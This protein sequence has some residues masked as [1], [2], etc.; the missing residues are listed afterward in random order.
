METCPGEQI[1][2]HGPDN[3][4]I[5]GAGWISDHVFAIETRQTARRGRFY[6]FHLSPDR[7]KNPT[8][9]DPTRALLSR[10]FPEYVLLLHGH[11]IRLPSRLRRPLFRRHHHPICSHLRARDQATGKDYLDGGLHQVFFLAVTEYLPS[12]AKIQA[13][14]VSASDRHCRCSWSHRRWVHFPDG[15]TLE[16]FEL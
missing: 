3:M 13:G 4:M 1:Q 16:R 7:S 8:Q 15:I 14:W 12:H 6:S 9:D 2:W 5:I 11:Q 10:L